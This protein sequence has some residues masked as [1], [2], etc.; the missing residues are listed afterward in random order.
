MR[1]VFFKIITS[2]F[3]AG[4]RFQP[5]RPTSR[6]VRVGG[7]VHDNYTFPVRTGGI[8]YFSGPGIDISCI[9]TNKQ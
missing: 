2:F 9:H 6:G 1:I 3:S 7:G 8:F 5:H 4:Q